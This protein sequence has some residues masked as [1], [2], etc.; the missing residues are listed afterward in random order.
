MEQ[1]GVINAQVDFPSG[2]ALVIFDPQQ[3][4]AETLAQALSEYYPAQVIRVMPIASP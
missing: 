2:Q 1:P 3:T 4:D